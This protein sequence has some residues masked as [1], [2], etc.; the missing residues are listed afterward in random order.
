MVRK[1]LRLVFPHKTIKEI[2]KIEKDF[3][4]H[5]ADITIESIKAFG[6]NENQMRNRYKYENIELIKDI[7]KKK[8]NII[9][10]LGHYS[11]F[12]WLLSIG[13]NVK[14]NGYAIFTPMTNKYF[15][16]LFEKIRMKHKAYLISRYKVKD[17]MSNLDTNKSVSYTHLTLPTTMWV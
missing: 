14:G 7:Q 17:F 3:Y 16:S 8:K 6:M 1:N 15:N 11:N 13:Y 12:E 10:I 9:L 2:K 4:K 5:F